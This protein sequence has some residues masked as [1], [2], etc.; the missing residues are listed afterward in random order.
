MAVFEERTWTEFPGGYGSFKGTKVT[1][2]RPV[3]C[4]GGIVEQ[5][6]TIG[7][8]VYTLVAYSTKCGGRYVKLTEEQ[9]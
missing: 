2:R 6:K 3:E 7:I 1:R 8:G 4:G 5:E 9:Q